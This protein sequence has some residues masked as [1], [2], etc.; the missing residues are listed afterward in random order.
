MALIWNAPRFLS[1]RDF[2]SVVRTARCRF[3]MLEKCFIE[4]ISAQAEVKIRL[5]SHTR[6]DLPPAAW[7]AFLPHIRRL[8]LLNWTEEQ[9]TL[10]RVLHANP[11]LTVEVRFSECKD[12][13]PMSTAEGRSCIIARGANPQQVESIIAQL[14]IM[15]RVGLVNFMHTLVFWDVVYPYQP[16]QCTMGVNTLVLKQSILTGPLTGVL[17]TPPK[18]LVIGGCV[19]LGSIMPGVT[20]L[21][22]YLR[23]I[24]S[25]L[26]VMD[27][28]LLPH[29]TSVTCICGPD[30]PTAL[31][32]LAAMHVLKREGMTALVFNTYMGDSEE[33][34]NA[35]LNR[36]ENIG[37]MQ[38]EGLITFDDRVH[39]EDVQIL[40]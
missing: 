22:V 21:V 14:N 19:C 38:G 8:V 34:Q 17:G 28:G 37:R 9:L 6:R 31:R 13:L 25:V 26:R 36:T 12:D 40:V 23:H 35:S 33:S 20:S 15:H 5:D 11:G 3:Y 30:K 2:T 29:L 39:F 4:C 24:S 7:L 16:P 18:Q 1:L 27:K 32:V 10:G